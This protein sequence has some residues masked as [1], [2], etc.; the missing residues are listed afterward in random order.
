MMKIMIAEDDL[1]VARSVESILAGAGHDIQVVQNGQQAFYRATSRHY[2]LLI[3]DLQMPQWDGVKCLDALASIC[4]Q[5]PVII[6]TALPLEEARARL[7]DRANVVSILEKS[8]DSATLLAALSGVNG[9]EYSHIQKLARIV[10]TVG[11]SC[12]DAET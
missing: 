9:S 8:V 3:S 4:P 5:L 1:T 10:C 11:P 6:L 7:G 2:D 12:G